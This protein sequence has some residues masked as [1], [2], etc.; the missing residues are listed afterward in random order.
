[1]NFI[2]KLVS[3]SVVLRYF[4]PEVAPDS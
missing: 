1:M 3:F 2:C 4:T